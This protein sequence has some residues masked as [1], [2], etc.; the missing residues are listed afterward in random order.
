MVTFNVFINFK[1]QSLEVLEKTKNI[2]IK[3]FIEKNFKNVTEYNQHKE[4]ILEEIKLNLEIM[5]DSKRIL[6]DTKTLETYLLPK[7][8]TSLI[9]MPEKTLLVD[10]LKSLEQKQ[11]TCELEYQ[12]IEKHKFI[13]KSKSEKISKINEVQH[14][15]NLKIDYDKSIDIFSETLS[16]LSKNFFC[17]GTDF[18]FN[19]ET[20]IEFK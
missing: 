12:K 7:L 10:S 15:K 1:L 18:C 9:L 11:K 6:S 3:K 16:C 17:T 14:R 13:N 4:N 8:V 20:F 19:S 5:Q 2:R